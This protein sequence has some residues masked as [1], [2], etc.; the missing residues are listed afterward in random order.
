MDLTDDRVDAHEA[1]LRR[2]PE[3]HSLLLRL[4]QAGVADPLICDYL[5]IEPEG[6]HTLL[7]VAERK[8]ATELA[9]G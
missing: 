7:E 2:L 6:L 9:R 4:R 3:T 1:A 8:L 5:H